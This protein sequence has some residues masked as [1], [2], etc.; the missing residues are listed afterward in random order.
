MLAEFEDASYASGV[1]TN[2]RKVDSNAMLQDVTVSI[3]LFRPDLAEQIISQ[4]MY[5]PVTPTRRPGDHADFSNAFGNMSLDSFALS[6]GGAGTTP[7]GIL[8]NASGVSY[9]ATPSNYPMTSTLPFTVGGLGSV[10][11]PRVVSPLQQTYHPGFGSPV[12]MGQS[13]SVF[14]SFGGHS[15]PQGG[16]PQRSFDSSARFQQSHLG[17]PLGYYSPRLH[18]PAHDVGN[19]NRTGSRHPYTPRAQQARTRQQSGPTNSHHNHVDIAKI[20]QGIDVR[21]TVSAFKM[22]LYLR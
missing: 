12:N 17:S 11:M 3:D 10:Y 16:F 5:A 1:V 8:A 9:M 18:E 21:T 6:P 22:L 14:H 19:Y 20:R 15:Y 7:A 2:G 4:Q 13:G